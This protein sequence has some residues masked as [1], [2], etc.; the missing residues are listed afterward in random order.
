MKYCTI[1]F[2]GNQYFID[3]HQYLYSLNTI[4]KPGHL[5]Q[6]YKILTLRYYDRYFI[7]CPY[8]ISSPIKLI[9]KSTARLFVRKLTIFKLKAKKKYR[10][11][12]GYREVK[13]RYIVCWIPN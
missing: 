7:G 13:N 10:R 8:L 4:N 11:Q 9:C 5:F 1:Q 2:Y 12:I 6:I 3:E